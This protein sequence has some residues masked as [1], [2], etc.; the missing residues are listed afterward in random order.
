MPSWFNGCKEKTHFSQL[1]VKS[2]SHICLQWN[3]QLSLSEISASWM[4]FSLYQSCPLAPGAMLFMFSLSVTLQHWV[5]LRQ[6]TRSHYQQTRA[7]THPSSAGTAIPTTP[8]LSIS[9]SVSF[10]LSFLLNRLL[11]LLLLLLLLT[12]LKLSSLR[13]PPWLDF[14]V[15]IEYTNTQIFFWFLLEILVGEPFFFLMPQRWW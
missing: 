7:C 14:F 1:D 4:N 9:L 15:T 6:R 3:I 5:M 8:V 13:R 11:P 12:A 2:N 10:S